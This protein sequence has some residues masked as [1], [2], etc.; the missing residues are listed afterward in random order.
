MTTRST[1]RPRCPA[2]SSGKVV[3]L[4]YARHGEVNGYQ[5]EDCTFVHVKPEGA[6][7]Y[8]LRVGDRLTATGERRTGA[9]AI[10]VEATKVTKR[11]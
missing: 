11:K 2:R 9:D 1:P 3:R 6:K 10:V 7:R 4:N 5:L 8:K